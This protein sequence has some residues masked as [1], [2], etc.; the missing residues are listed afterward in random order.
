MARRTIGTDI[1][2]GTRIAEDLPAVLADSGGLES[3]LLNLFVNSRDAMPQG[4]AITVA[5]RLAELDEQYAG[6][7]A[8]ELKAGCYM[9]IAVSDTGRG[10]APEVL[11]RAFE[12][13]FT[14]KE[15]GKGT[16]MGLAMVYGFA[17]QSGG[18]ASIYSEPGRGTTVKLYLP[19]AEPGAVASAA[20]KAPEDDAPLTGTALVVDDEAD[21][22]EVAVAYLEEMG[23]R[24]LHAM[25]GPGALEVL[26][27]EPA[28]DLLLTDIMMPGGMNGVEHA[29]R[30]AAARPG[31]RVIYCTGFS[32]AALSEKNGT[33]VDGP[34][35]NKPYRRA[36]FFE[37]I[38][39]AM[40]VTP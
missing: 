40:S 23:F 36:E 4:G 31:I 28:V 7:R 17:K 18:H 32:S 13:F 37:A 24:V 19:L 6:V 12:P 35:L 25:D 34:S 33:A 26:G 11:Q 15:R 29:R 5:A 20:P 10:M 2:I 22:L 30:A 3:A 8:S 21:L 39:R 1:E 27:R 38:R 9:C 14:T 16:G